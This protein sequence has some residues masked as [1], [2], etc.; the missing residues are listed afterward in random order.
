[1]YINC[2]N[3]IFIAQQYLHIRPWYCN[4]FSAV[5]GDRTVENED[6]QKQNPLAIHMNVK[7]IHSIRKSNQRMAWSYV[8]FN[9][10]NNSKLPALHFHSGGMQEM[11]S[12]LQRYIWLTKYF[13]VWMYSIPEFNQNVKNFIFV[14][15]TKFCYK[16]KTFIRRSDK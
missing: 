4:I 5:D 8:M 15:N 1:M 12:T 13:F 9:L 7:E 6:S 10:K 11:I 2:Q 14:N 3:V 16:N